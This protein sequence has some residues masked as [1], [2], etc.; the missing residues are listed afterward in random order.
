MKLRKVIALLSVLAIIIVS[1]STNDEK[2]FYEQNDTNQFELSKTE[3]KGCFV[4]NPFDSNKNLLSMTSDS[5]FYTIANDTLLLHMIMNYNCCGLL[6]DSLSID[7]EN[8]RIYIRDTCI[9]NCLC[10][11][12]CDFEFEYS[13]INFLEKNIH[14]YVYLK[15]YEEYEYSLWKDLEYNE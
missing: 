13:F 12:M 7:A 8:V 10:Y 4:D 3:Y 9:A 5:L 1:C 11:C 15:G 14:F 6:N 2:G